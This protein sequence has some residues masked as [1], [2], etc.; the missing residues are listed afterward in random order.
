MCLHPEAEDASTLAAVSL[1]LLFLS[2]A[3][4]H[5]TRVI[6]P[7]RR[8]SSRSVNRHDVESERGGGDTTGSLLVNPGSGATHPE[9]N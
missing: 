4:S 8:V 7:S 6:A 5:S 9:V 2:G 1:E 3:A